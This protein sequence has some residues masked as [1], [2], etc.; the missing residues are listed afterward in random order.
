MP[1]KEM[2]TCKNKENSHCCVV[3]SLAEQCFKDG[4]YF[5]PKSTVVDS[6]YSFFRLCKKN[7]LEV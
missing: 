4:D 5:F 7:A 1:L 3:R 2:R 6:F